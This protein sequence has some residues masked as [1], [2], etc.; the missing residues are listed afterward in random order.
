[1]STSPPLPDLELLVRRTRPVLASKLGVFLLC[2]LRYVLQTENAGAQNT[3][4]G[5]MALRLT[6]THRTIAP[7]GRRRDLSSKELRQAFLGAVADTLRG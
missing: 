5:L 7:L 4:P 2:P 6:A 3:P 1:M